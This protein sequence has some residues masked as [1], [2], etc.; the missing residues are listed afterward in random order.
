MEEERYLRKAYDARPEEKRPRDRR[1]VT[2]EDLGL[3]FM[4][5]IGL[6]TDEEIDTGQDQMVLP[7]QILTP[8]R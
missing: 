5:V 3:F 4:T 1:R 7:L 6:E 2:W 8:S